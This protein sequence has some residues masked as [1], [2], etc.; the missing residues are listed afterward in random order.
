MTT[1]QIPNPIKYH[2]KKIKVSKDVYELVERQ[3]RY[4]LGWTGELELLYG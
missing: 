1:M 3:Q 2:Y 4:L